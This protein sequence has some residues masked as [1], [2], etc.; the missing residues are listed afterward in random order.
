MTEA[1]RDVRTLVVGL[2]VQGRKRHSL[3]GGTAVGTVDPSVS[4]ADYRLLEAVP[5]HSF[6]CALVCVPD[7][8][9]P[10]VIEYLIAAGKHVL[11]EKP[12]LLPSLA[13][14]E[15]LQAKA[16]NQS[17]VVYVA[18]NHRFE[19]HVQRMTETL[20]SGLLG[21][22][23]A[24]RLFYGNGTAQ[25]VQQSPWRD[26]GLGVLSDLG[27]HLLNLTD[28][29][30][31]GHRD[32]FRL[33]GVDRFENAAPDHAL[34]VSEGSAPRLVLEMSLCSWQNEFSCDVFAELGSA[35]IRGL[36]KWGPSTFHRRE[37]IHPSGVP[38]TESITLVQPD[39]T[40]LLEYQHFLA[41]IARG[42]ATSLVGDEWIARTLTH[43]GA[44]I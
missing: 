5:T 20:Q 24:C 23:Y 40:W 17:V 33:V 14:Y 43:V 1:L 37:R 9:K 8:A 39:P 4:D 36:C 27:S 26:I 13:D 15:D 18:Y 29:W 34:V 42:S 19:P 28:L 44:A 31:S 7:A 30:F 12:L 2:G 25:L 35:H 3:L 16:R 6:D 32:D 41:L 21:R 10:K 38:L 11:V 22:L